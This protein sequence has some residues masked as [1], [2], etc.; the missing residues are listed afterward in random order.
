MAIPNL[1]TPGSQRLVVHKDVLSQLDPSVSARITEDKHLEYLQ[2][3]QD[4]F[5]VGQRPLPAEEPSADQISA[6]AAQLEANLPPA[7]DFSLFGQHYSRSIRVIK[8]RAAKFNSDGQL[9][10]VELKGPQ[11]YDTWS[12]CYSVWS[13]AML[14]LNAMD[15]GILNAYRTLIHAST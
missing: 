13:N 3:Y 10:Q 1:L 6:L 2:R 8:L 11:D 5:G 4:H 7:V 15:L 12:A 14:V 9:A